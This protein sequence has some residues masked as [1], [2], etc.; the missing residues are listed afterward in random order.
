MSK[1]CP[2]CGK[3]NNDKATFCLNCGSTFPNIKKEK[4]VKPKQN[5]TKQ[6]SVT[7]PDNS[8]I[9]K[10]LIVA[11]VLAVILVGSFYAYTLLTTKTYNADTWS[12]NYPADGSYSLDSSTNTVY[13]Y[14][15]NSEEIFEVTE[16]SYIYS[17]ASEVEAALGL[18]YPYNETTIN[19]QKAFKINYNSTEGEVTYYIFPNKG[20]FITI[21]KN[22]DSQTIINSL[23]FK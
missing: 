15:H 1:Y 8:K 7:E 12:I 2:N 9:K 11:I 22:Q 13:F 21:P 5:K 14:N 17:S 18:V 6:K 16:L 3:E 4:T 10:I 20:L 19:G 23:K